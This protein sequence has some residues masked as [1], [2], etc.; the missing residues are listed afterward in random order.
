MPRYVRYLNLVYMIDILSLGHTT[1]NFNT[2]VYRYCVLP[3]APQA[4]QASPPFQIIHAFV[5][6]TIWGALFLKP[7][8]V[9]KDSIPDPDTWGGNRNKS[10]GYGKG[11][12]LL[13]SV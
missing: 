5:V 2:C 10:K 7:I 12:S 4:H 11:K 8:S 13:V 3:G 1:D 6:E 9:A